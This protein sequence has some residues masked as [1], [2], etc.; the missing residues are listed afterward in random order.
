MALA[1]PPCRDRPRDPPRILKGIALL[2]GINISISG[3]F[4]LYTL[5][6]PFA[7]QEPDGTAFFLDLMGIGLLTAASACVWSGTRWGWWL[8]VAAVVPLALS[9]FVVV[10]RTLPRLHP[11]LDMFG[12]LFEGVA[13][14]IG[15]LRLAPLIALLIPDVGRWCG[16]RFIGP[17]RQL[18]ESPSAGAR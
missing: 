1:P 17:T 6:D 5:V 2:L 12:W 4:T 8:S 7:E 16:V 18:S 15:A 14:T 13:L 10:A 11:T 9:G 3:L